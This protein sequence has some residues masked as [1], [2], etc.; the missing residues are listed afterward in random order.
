MTCADCQVCLRQDSGQAGDVA[1]GIADDR[2][3]R[4]FGLL[5]AR[6]AE[7]LDDTPQLGGGDSGRIVH[8]LK[9]D[10]GPHAF[11]KVERGVPEGR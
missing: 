3:V 7:P 11:P 2:D 9:P 8:R 6:G 4:V 1:A 10:H 5:L